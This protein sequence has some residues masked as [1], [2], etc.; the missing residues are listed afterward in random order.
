MPK[1]VDNKSVTIYDIAREAGVSPATVSRV[2]TNRAK[3]SS[4]KREKVLEV[5]EKYSFQP[6]ILAKGLAN[7]GT[8]AIGIMTADVRNPF[9]ASLFVACEQAAKELGYTVSLC[10]SLDVKEQEIELLTKMRDQKVDAMIQI[11]G[12]ADDRVSDE[13]YVEAVNR[14]A[15]DIPFVTSGKL[16][17]TG[18]YMVGL[19]N[20]KALE[21]LMN[22]LL[23]LNHM[24]IALIG[25]G[26]DVM[27]TY[28]KY[29]R[30]KQILWENGL[31]FDRELLG[32]D[33]GYD[34]ESGYR[35]IKKMLEK[36]VKLTA[37][38]AINDLA[39]TG[40]IR[41][42][43]DYGYQVPEDVSVVS[44]DNTAIARIITP[45]L[46]SIDYNYEDFGNRLVRTAVD[47]LEGKETKRLQ[48]VEPKLVI[49][50]SSG[51]APDHE[52]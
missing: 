20:R 26:M 49:R 16:D 42:L 2:M 52:R 13:E 8:R 18:C 25:G 5:I 29:Q 32:E 31:E 30:Y 19:N 45:S 41:C 1:T 12:S 37:V 47:L 14:I 10:N 4:D 21:L 17:G 11:G 38:I 35:E 23:D 22:H 48:I 28:E 51:P 40:V 9:Y 36:K 34:F 43:Q 50:K 7:A 44:Y 3:V 46:T 15:S 27:S 24:R 33:S 39:A 6:N